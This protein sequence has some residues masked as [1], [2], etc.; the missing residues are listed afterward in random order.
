MW[1]L[2][3]G[4]VI[5][6]IAVATGSALAKGSYTRPPEPRLV[7]AGISTPS[8]SPGLM[9]GGCGPKR[10]RD[11]VTQKCRGPADIGN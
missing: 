2:I 4:L 7:T 5:P 10:V 1:R 9:L 6:L 11:P 3:A 8:A